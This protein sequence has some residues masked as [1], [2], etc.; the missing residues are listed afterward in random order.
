MASAMVSTPPGWPREFT[1]SSLGP[2][3]F[4]VIPIREKQ[5]KEKK[6]KVRRTDFNFLSPFV[7]PTHLEDPKTSKT[8]RVVVLDLDET[9]VKSFHLPEELASIDTLK[10][11]SSPDHSELRLIVK[12]LSVENPYSIP[13]AGVKIKVYMVYRPGLKKFLSRLTHWASSII[14]LT[15]GKASYAWK[16]FQ[17]IW[18]DLPM[19]RALLTA[20]ICDEEVVDVPGIG[21]QRRLYKRLEKIYTM[22]P[23][24]ARPDNTI[25]IDNAE[26]NTKPNPQNSILIP[27]YEPRPTIEGITAHDDRLGKI[28]DFLDPKEKQNQYTEIAHGDVRKVDLTK[29]FA[30]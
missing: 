12:H 9:L 30:E 16:A 6:A 28:M 10:I 25:L 23:G 17:Q 3:A 2:P 20:D 18:S 11:W 4:T 15:A 21:R 22:Y 24:E 26:Y 27:D 8:D 1:A 29:I 7:Y 13:G 14:V 19:P 5:V